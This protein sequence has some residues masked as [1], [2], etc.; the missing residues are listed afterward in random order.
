MSFRNMEMLDRRGPSSRFCAAKPLSLSLRML[1]R[2]KACDGMSG[3]LIYLMVVFSPWAFGTTQPWSIWTM[4]CLGYALG[5]LLSIK[6]AIR[7]LTGYRNPRWAA[8]GDETSEGLS[9]SG[10]RVRAL[11]RALA[12]LTVLVLVYCFVSAINARSHYHAKEARFEYFHFISW[13]PHSYD[14][15]SSWQAFWNYLALGLSFWALH[16]W[17]VGKSPVEERADRSKHVDFRSKRV[18]LVPERLRRLLWVLSINGGLLGLEGIIQRIV[19][20]NHLLFLVGTRINREAESQFGPYA[21]RSNAAQYFNLV[22]PVCLGFWWTMQRAARAEF[23]NAKRFDLGWHHIIL[24]CVM[25]MATCPIIST[26]RAGAFVA[27][28]NLL[29]A[30]AILWSA[31]RRGDLKAKMRVLAFLGL[32]LGFGA[33]LGWEKLA[34]RFEAGTFHEGLAGRNAI[35][36][37]AR[38][39]ASDYPLFGTGPGTFASLFQFYR[40]DPDEYWPAQLH[41]DWLETRITFGWLGSLLVALSLGVVLTRWVVPGGIHG[42]VRLVMLLWVALA[43][44]LLHARYDFPFQIYSILFAFLVIC[45]ILFSIS[46]TSHVASSDG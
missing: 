5:A 23:R 28:L 22:W 13:L 17:V 39:M 10:L 42:G 45:A 24:V 20:T 18:M 27:V 29:A 4:N 26:T 38:P 6:L 40:V 9:K 2:Y 7:W 12:I 36:D 11:T 43:G 21:Y 15:K 34:P 30:A 44:C 1:Q 41:N 32:I 8:R 37:T 46:R 31:Q 33:L 14:Q 19:G 16:E 35:Y 25:I 3:K